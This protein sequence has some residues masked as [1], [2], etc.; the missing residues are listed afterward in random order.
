M[1]TNKYTYETIL[2]QNNGFGWDDVEYFETNST[3]TGMNKEERAELKRLKIE[4]RIA[5]PSAPLRV[6][7]RMTPVTH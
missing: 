3:H 1:K 2:Q 6:I 7:H 5:Q 4:Y